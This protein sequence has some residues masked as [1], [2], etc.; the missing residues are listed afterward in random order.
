MSPHDDDDLCDFADVDLA[1]DVGGLGEGCGFGGVGGFGDV[2][3]DQMGN[4][5]GGS[6]GLK[7]MS[8]FSMHMSSSW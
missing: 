5:G 6:G 2:G 8:P 7:I 1:G 4:C 3:G